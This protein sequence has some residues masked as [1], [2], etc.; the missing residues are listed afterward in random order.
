[1]RETKGCWFPFENDTMLTVKAPIWMTAARKPSHG[2]D[3]IGEHSDEISA[4][5]GYD[6]AV[7][8]AMRAS[9][10]RWRNRVTFDHRYRVRTL[11]LSTQLGYLQLC[12]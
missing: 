4:R 6:E 7:R 8:P 5:A 10:A 1:M 9:G 12:N 3:G 2:I 11:L